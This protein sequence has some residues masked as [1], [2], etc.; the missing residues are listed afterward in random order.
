VE[1]LDRESNKAFYNSE[2]E[3]DRERFAR[4]PSKLHTAELLVPWVTSCLRPGDKLLDVAGGSGSYASAMVRAVPVTVVGVDISESMI[5]Q[6]SEDPL[7]EH[8]V[9]G[10]MEALPFGD[11]E[12]DAVM[13][14]AA[15]HHVPD[16][17]RALQE[18]LRVLRPGGRLFALEP[19]SIRS[20]RRG[21]RPVPGLPHEFAVS[22]WWLAE[23]MKA[24]G[25]DVEH[26]RMRNLSIRVLSRVMRRPSTALFRAGDAIDRVL[27]L[28]PGLGRLSET[29]L[30][31]AVKRA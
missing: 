15:L 16:P 5:R 10:D 27:R 25:F 21:A 30:I 18:A 3:H 1:R 14:V 28:V 13:F 17:S 8:N 22:A 9:V 26:V 31:Q 12:F 29:G 11:G 6:R 23:Q 20:A 24:A 19:S 2:R 4:E 7:L